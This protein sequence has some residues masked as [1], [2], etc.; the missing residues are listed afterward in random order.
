MNCC[1]FSSVPG[2]QKWI[3]IMSRTSDS[4]DDT[5]V[6]YIPLITESRWR[7]FSTIA[8]CFCSWFVDI[9]SF[10]RMQ[11]IN[12]SFPVTRH[13]WTRSIYRLW[14]FVPINK[15]S[16][17]VNNNNMLSLFQLYIQATPILA[18]EW[19]SNMSIT[20]PRNMR[21]GLLVREAFLAN[22]THS[23]SGDGWL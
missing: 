10:D 7:S 12:T 9:V 16:Q 11:T 8:L 15:W 3:E 13:R 5:L 23:W 4:S 22:Q 1:R 2:V 18:A 20:L 19:K 17:Q 14:K 21:N 6:R